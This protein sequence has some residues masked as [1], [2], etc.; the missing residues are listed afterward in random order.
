IDP[1]QSTL[2]DTPHQERSGYGLNL[3]VTSFSRRFGLELGVGSPSASS[4]PGRPALA[5]AAPA[6]EGLR[7][8]QVPAAD[9]RVMRR[10]LSRYFPAPSGVSAEVRE[11]RI[12]VLKPHHDRLILQYDLALADKRRGTQFGGSLVGAWRQDERG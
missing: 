12:R 3:R 11:C 10:L 1:R 5:A 9:P 4:A 8:P 2:W 6:P 7:V